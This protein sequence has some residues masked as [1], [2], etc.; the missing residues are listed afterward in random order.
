MD[1]KTFIIGIDLGTSVSR[2]GV[3]SDGRITVIDKDV[4][5]YVAFTDSERL[6]GAAAKRQAAVNPTN[7]IYGYC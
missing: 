6:I 1:K 2:V 5:S 7:T 3:Y 4:P